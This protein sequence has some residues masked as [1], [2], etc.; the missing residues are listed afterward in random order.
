MA[1]AIKSIPVLNG[2]EAEDFV[3][4]ADAAFHNKQKSNQNEK[5]FDSL[6]RILRKANMK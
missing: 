2:K 4:K 6:N 3:K 5:R 1:I